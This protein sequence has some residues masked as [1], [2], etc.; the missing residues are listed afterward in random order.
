VTEVSQEQQGSPAG[1]NTSELG[2]RETSELGSAGETDQ[3]ER[4]PTEVATLESC[5]RPP[6]GE[7]NDLTQMLAGIMAAIQ[8]T[9]ENVKAELVANKESVRAELVA[10][11]EILKESVRS[12]LATSHENFKAEVSKIRKQMQLENEELTK[13]FEKQI[14]Q[15]QKEWSG[16]LDLES[17]RLTNLVKQAQKETEAELLGFKK[18]LQTATSAFD[19]KLEHTN[20]TTQTVI[21]GLVSHVEERQSEVDNKIQEISS[22]IEQQKE[23]N[24]QTGIEQ[25]FDQV[26]ARIVALETKV[27]EPNYNNANLPGPSGVLTSDQQQTQ[28]QNGESR[29]CSCQSGTCSEC[30]SY[31]T[32][33]CRMNGNNQQQVANFLNSTELP[34]P[35]FDEAK[36]TNPVYHLKQLEEFMR[37]RGVPKELHLAVA[38]RS[39]TGQMAKQWAETTSW[40]IKDYPEFCREFLKVWWSSSRQ[41]LVKCKLYQGKYNRSSGLSLSAYFL[42]QATTASYLEPRL[43]DIEVIEAIRFHYP[44][45][46]QKI[47]ISNQLNSVTQTLDLLKR[48]EVLESGEGYQ[49]P[50][51]QVQQNN[52]SANRQ[53]QTRHNDRRAQPQGQV[54]QIQVG[55]FHRNNNYNRN[56]R[57]GNRNQQDRPQH[58]NPNAPSFPSNQQQGAPSE[59]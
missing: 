31:N 15:S 41:N 30:M 9:N 10:N 36:N 29:T 20:S 37:L 45:S 23:S 6:H 59:N 58:L 3:V 32:N 21:E 14:Q 12:E 11:N 27:S 43:S 2:S 18:Q 7:S 26:D 50:N 24:N 1:E 8:Q 48:I 46:I 17:R 44:V 19:E 38:Y 5:Q 33:T 52:P 22:R 54:R 13:R 16:K 51:N 57:R 55:N 56:W 49:R 53:D 4:D 39:M 47:L 25:K 28:V 42:Q 35:Q 34:L 40:S